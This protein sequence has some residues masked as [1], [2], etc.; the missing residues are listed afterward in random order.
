MARSLRKVMGKEEGGGKKGEEKK[1]VKSEKEAVVKNNP[2][3]LNDWMVSGWQ[4]I[5]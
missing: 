3:E 2:A 5:W 4:Q 1:G